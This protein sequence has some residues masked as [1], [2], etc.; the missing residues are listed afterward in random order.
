MIFITQLIYLKE[1]MQQ[2]FDEFEAVAIPSISRYNGTMLF[3]IR[4]S[5][6]TVLQSSIE[7][8][9]E[10]HMAQFESDTDFNSFLNDPE[11]KRFLHLKEAS[12]RSTILIKGNKLLSLFPG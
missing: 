9:Y 4:P 5:K 12:I 3:R 10:V 11:R 1:G 7:V 2:I 6:E 8:P